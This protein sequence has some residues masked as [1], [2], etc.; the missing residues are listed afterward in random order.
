MPTPTSQPRSLTVVVN[1]T[2]VDDLDEAKRVVRKVLSEHGWPEP[3]WVPTTEAD[4]GEKQA[5][6][7]IAAGAEV[8]AA[9]GGDGTVRAVA[10]A[11]RGSDV[12]LGLL[13]GGTGNLLARN[14][15]LP[16]D[17]LE[18]A[19]TALVTG[20]ERRIDVGL[21]SADDDPEEVFLVMSG[22]GLDGAIMAGTNERIKGAIGWPAYVLA[23]AK[24]LAQRG[25][26]VR[27]NAEGEPSAPVRRHRAST[28]VIG[29]C[30]TL[31]GGIELLPDA[32]LDDGQL[33]GV[34]LAPTGLVGWTSV[35]ADL[36]SRHRAGQGRLERL[37]A[38]AFTIEAERPVEAE[39]DGDPI[40]P[41]RRMVLRVDAAALLVRGA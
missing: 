40:G 23:A 32:R 1:P 8:V 28:V 15:E 33:D 31:Q 29:N 25:F 34:V 20:G 36:V 22:L 10:T 26:R 18:D 35:A 30:G 19:T 17:S 12:A 11:L 16:V 37:R 39:I 13:P 6:E 21:V 3:T 24:G 27:V 38:P 14:L 2:K 5:R 7:A 4:T 9:Y 41:R